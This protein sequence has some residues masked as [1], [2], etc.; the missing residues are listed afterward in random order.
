MNN[1]EFSQ[2][3]HYLGRSQSQLALLLCVSTKAIQSFEQGWR[4]I[5]FHIER[6]LRLILAL[7]KMGKGQ[8]VV[9]CW[10]TKCCPPEWR[11]KCIVWELKARHFCW[12]ISG[13]FCEGR[14][15]GSWKKKEKICRKCVVYKETISGVRIGSD[16]D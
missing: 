4:K 9:P 3:R 11:A 12:F 16:R 6:Q 13:T 7:K 2:I 10:E 14:F 8:A 1:K 5:P 15:Q